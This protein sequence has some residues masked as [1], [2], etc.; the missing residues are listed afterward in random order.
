[1]IHNDMMHIIVSIIF[2]TD[3][4][5][6]V[7]QTQLSFFL[8]FTSRV[9]V[10]CPQLLLSRADLSVLHSYVPTCNL[11]HPPKVKRPAPDHIPNSVCVRHPS[12]PKNWIPTA[13]LTI[14]S[15]C[16]PNMSTLTFLTFIFGENWDTPMFFQHSTSSAR[17]FFLGRP[18][19]I[20]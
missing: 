3:G 11:S 12:I 20:W 10:S 18:V 2:S 8:F 15:P 17:V 19:N 7:L 5:T 16:I 9:G 1:M 13:S 6:P 14:F 4:H